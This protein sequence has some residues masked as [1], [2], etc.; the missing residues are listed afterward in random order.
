MGPHMSTVACH[1]LM[2]HP[3]EAKKINLTLKTHRH[4]FMIGLYL[5]PAVPPTL[6]GVLQDLPT[7]L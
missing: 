5:Y 2:F 6:Q 1:R 7:Y 3:I 4:T